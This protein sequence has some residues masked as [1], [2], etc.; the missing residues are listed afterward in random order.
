ME[1]IEN[2]EQINTL[3]AIFKAM[4]IK[5]SIKKGKEYDPEFVA[6]VLEGDEDIKAGKTTKVSD[7]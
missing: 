6:K 1:S 5:F 4:K 2:K 3:K 7:Y